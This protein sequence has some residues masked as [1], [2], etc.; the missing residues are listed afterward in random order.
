MNKSFLLIATIAVAALAACSKTEE[1]QAP[2]PVSA[3]VSA[4][5]PAPVSSPVSAPVT[6]ASA[7]ETGAPAVATDAS[8]AT[9]ATAATAATSEVKK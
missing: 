8:G 3:P 9:A 5:A 7:V 6:S 1:A 4:P 2:A